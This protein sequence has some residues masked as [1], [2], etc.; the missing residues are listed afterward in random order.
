MAIS[1]RTVVA[2][3]AAAAV[4][5]RLARAGSADDGVGTP[6][7]AK[8]LRYAFE[9]AETSLDPVKVSD[10]YSRTLTPH[11]FEAPLHLRPP[12]AAG[13]DQAAHGRR[14]AAALR[15]LPRLD[16]ARS[17]PAS[18]SPTI[19][20]SRASGASWSRRTTSTR[21]KRFADPAN[22]SPAWTQ[23]RE[24]GPRRPGRAAPA[25]ASTRR[26]RSTTTSEI[27]GLR[28]LDRY[29]LR[30]AVKEPR[31]R[32]L[33]TL[34]GERSAAAR[35]RAR[36]SSS[37]ATRSR[38]IRSAPA[39]SS[40]SSGGAARSSLSS[41]TPTSARCSTTPSPP[42]TTPKARRC[43]RAS[44]AAGCRWSIASR[45]RSSRRSSR[46]GSSFVN[47]EADVAYRVGYQFAPQAMPNGKIAPNL[48]KRGIRG[49]PV[50]RGR[51]QQLSSSTW[52]IPVVGGYA[53]AQVALRR[54]I[55]LGIDSRKIIAYAYNG[56]GAAGAG[57][58][59]AAHQRLRSEAEDRVQRLRPGARAGAARPV[60]LRRQGRRRLARA[61][62]RLA[63]RARASRPSRSCAIARSPR[64]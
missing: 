12:G 29:T 23:P 22:K 14:H 62:R 45:S 8:V 53:P 34:A 54:A 63:A 26:S 16:G 2:G 40:S 49:Y 64:C 17:G 7:P 13:Q 33:E 43:W 35:S 31:P 18:T 3:A 10:L 1:R 51:R 50:D 24:R 6:A 5:P 36:W 61:A 30:F 57:A 20:R 60:R 44:R 39:R 37:T 25:R 38:R 42:P 9:V 32:F 21:I 15:R 55:G 46:A 59:P 58:D 48:A 19:R 47:G 11:I 27:E 52:R 28:A 4:A 56:L 41:A